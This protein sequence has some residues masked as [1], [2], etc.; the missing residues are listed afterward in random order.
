MVY[1]Y[2][3]EVCELNTAKNAR[4]QDNPKK[5]ENIKCIIEGNKYPKQKKTKRPKKKIKE[6]L[7]TSH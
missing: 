7:M 3:N 2:L 6:K 4:I 1:Y 5:L